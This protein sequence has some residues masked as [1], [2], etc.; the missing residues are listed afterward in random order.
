MVE[1][2]ELKQVIRRDLLL[3]VNPVSRMV[4]T[5]PAGVGKT[6]LAKWIVDQQKN[7]ILYIDCI[8][9]I[10]RNSIEKLDAIQYHIAF[11][12]QQSNKTNN[13]FAII[14]DN[15]DILFD[16]KESIA[17]F[18]R[19]KVSII[20][21]TRKLDDLYPEIYLNE[22][23]E[24]IKLLRPDRAGSIKILEQLTSNLDIME[25]FIPTVINTIFDDTKIINRIRVPNGV[26]AIDLPVHFKNF[27]SWRML[28]EIVQTGL[29]YA[30]FYNM[31]IDT[32]AAEL[33]V[34]NVMQRLGSY[35]DLEKEIYNDR[36]NHVIARF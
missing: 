35:P 13:H 21:V 29:R 23:C 7:N 24:I 10:N 3:P 4:I 26:S 12:V 18:D 15:A 2:D 33:A 19:P 27:V 17:Q 25:G 8:G 22:R 30:D 32:H 14:F 6:M 36:A 5:G 16:C 9:Y 31:T 34:N 28:D 20:L 11:A 1:Y